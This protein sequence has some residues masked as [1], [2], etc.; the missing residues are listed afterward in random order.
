MRIN[1][2]QIFLFIKVFL[3]F[4]FYGYVCINSYIIFK[5]FSV[6]IINVYIYCLACKIIDEYIKARNNV[7]GIIKHDDSNYETE[8]ELGKGKCKKKNKI[9]SSSDSEE[10]KPVKKLINKAVAPPP[11]VQ[12]PSRSDF[13]DSV[14]SC[15]YFNENQNKKLNI[16]IYS[17][18]S[19]KKQQTSFHSDVKGKA[20]LV[21]NVLDA[22]KRTAE[23]FKKKMSLQSLSSNKV[24]NVTNSLKKQ[25]QKH[26]IE[27][28]HTHTEKS[29]YNKQTLSDMRIM[30]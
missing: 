13:Y 17:N 20:L 21:Q 24:M 10:E 3:V 9:L 11:N 2:A 15:S 14:P 28:M 29:K 4:L 8:K 12:L 23:Q 5:K 6:L 27:L 25:S 18:K 7:Q 26:Q 1:L 30:K 16:K 19:Q 22:R